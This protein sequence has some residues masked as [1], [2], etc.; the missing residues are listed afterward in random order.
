MPHFLTRTDFPD[1]LKALEWE[2]Y[3]CIAPQVRQG[4]I[5]FDTL[6]SVAQLPTG[7]QDTQ[8]PGHYRLHQTGSPYWFDWANGASAIKPHTFAPQESLWKVVRDESGRLHFKTILPK[9][10]K[11][12]ILGVRACDLAALALQDQHFLHGEYP[13]PYYQQRRENLLLIG[14]NCTHAAA[15]C[16]CVSTGDGPA[17]RSD[18]DLLL[19]ETADGFV[20]ETGSE[21]G[22]QL[23]SLLPLH[24]ASATQ[25]ATAQQRMQA[26][27][28]QSRHLPEKPP[29][30][31]LLQHPHWEEVGARCIACGNCTSVCPT[32]VCHQEV[33]R[34]A[35]DGN[36]S[37]HERLW[38]SCFDPSHSH[39]HGGAVRRTHKNYYRQWLTHK[40]AGWHE[41]FGRS[42]C[43]GCGRC[44]T[45]CPVGIDLTAEV[46]A[47]ASTTLSERG[48][49]LSERESSL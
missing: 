36:S 6:S 37:T 14:V 8:E 23:A 17:I 22:K 9:P 29:L 3:A 35:L 43:T 1:L 20:L 5:V 47:I 38:N 39:I 18:Y 19:S 27:T 12:A 44:L 30:Y 10:Q 25:Q 2:G 16:F 41:Q 7:W 33:E 26:A 32:C 28:Q 49:V 15:T 11:T 31:E 42:G 4:A 21:R 24:E 46:A 34:P 45:W 40:L 48:S 13:D